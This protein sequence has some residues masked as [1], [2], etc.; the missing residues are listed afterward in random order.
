MGAEI[1]VPLAIAAAS[2]GVQYYNTRQTAKKQDNTLAAQLR[3]DAD[4][5]KQADAQTQQL[6]AKT[7]SSTDADE[8]AGSLA[9][10]TQA[11]QANQAN[12][13]RPLQTQGAVSDAYKKAGSDAALGIAS[14]AGGLADLVSSID[15]PTQ[16]RQNDVR[17]LDDFKTNIGMIRRDS[18]GDDFLSQMRLRG[19]KRNPWLDAA[20]QVGTSYASNYGGRASGASGA[21]S[22]NTYYDGQFT[23]NLPSY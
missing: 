19:I 13:T 18:A 17:D 9:K 7:R 6:I 10:F 8:K 1:L 14:K 3:A 11:I 12:A 20:S 2:A 5:Q 23:Y 4:K 16:Q 15:A 22:P 21:S